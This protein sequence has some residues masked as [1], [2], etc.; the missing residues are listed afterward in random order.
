[1]KN[2]CCHLL[3]IYLTAL[4]FMALSN[5]T[6]ATPKLT[7]NELTHIAIQNNNDLKAAQYNISLAKARL[8]QAGLWPNPS[9]NL[10]N[11]DDKLLTNEGEYTRSAGFSQAF[12]LSGRIG[13]Q[14][15]VAR[16]DVALARAE[17]RNA[18]RLLKGAV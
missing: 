6:Q 18:K 11:T 17:I 3:V 15:N 1:M 14:K 13:K 2:F 16:V 5:I 10:L 7:L 9:L 4:T 12:P 8:T